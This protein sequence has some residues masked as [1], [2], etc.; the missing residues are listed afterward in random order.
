MADIPVGM[1]LQNDLVRQPQRACGAADELP[2]AAYLKYVRYRAQTPA[3]GRTPSAPAVIA[4][5]AIWERVDALSRK[6]E[7]RN[8]LEPRGS[9]KGVCVI[10]IN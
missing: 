9:V 7:Q 5:N 6:L 1:A 10:E 3:R 8:S 4:V 2:H